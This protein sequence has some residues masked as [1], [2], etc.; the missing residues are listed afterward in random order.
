MSF[1]YIAV[2]LLVCFTHSFATK[3]ISNYTNISSSFSTDYCSNNSQTYDCTPNNWNQSQQCQYV[4]NCCSNIL[5]DAALFDYLQFE[6]CA[7]NDRQWL[8]ILTFVIAVVY[9][10]II[11]SNIADDY[12]AP[13]M[14]ELADYL[15]ISDELAG[16]TFLALGNGAPDISSAITAITKGGNTTQ[17]GIGALLGAAVFDPIVV[18]AV[19]AMVCDQPK[20]ARRPFLRDCF[21]LF[22]A[23]SCVLF[24]T[25]YLITFFCAKVRTIA[26]FAFFM[27]K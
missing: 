23:A 15:N 1:F 5:T 2:V 17:L 19:I 24:I 9:T 26:M 18:S 27:K 10:F 20:V 25:R 14:S 8:G 3:I 11:L 16:V 22:I 6:Y 4:Q 12:F 13:I 7:M 21:F